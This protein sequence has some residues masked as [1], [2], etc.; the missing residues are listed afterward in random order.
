MNF[1]KEVA[2]R[3][4]LSFLNWLSP[5]R[6]SEKIVWQRNNSKIEALSTKRHDILCVTFK[7]LQK[8]VLANEMIGEAL[9]PYYRQILPIFNL[10]KYKRS[11]N[12]FIEKKFFNDFK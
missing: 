11:K 8:L 12:S 9:V 6:V 10:F 3:S 4:C 1:W 2:L 7:K 5:L